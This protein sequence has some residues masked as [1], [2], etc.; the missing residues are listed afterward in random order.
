[1]SESF[2]EYHNRLLTYVASTIPVYCIRYED[3]R[4]KPQETLEKVFCFLLNLES[5]EGTNI[6][7]RIKEV[8]SLGHS[9]SV[10]YK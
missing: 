4:S 1:M 8:V 5:V 7:R 9:A 2:A 10:V 6:Q 3:L